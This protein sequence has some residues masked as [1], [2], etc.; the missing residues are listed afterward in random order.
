[1]A[2]PDTSSPVQHTDETLDIFGRP[3]GWMLHWGSGLVVILFGL[4]I[5]FAGLVRYP[6]KILASVV[7]T[8][9]NP[10]VPV[11]VRMDGVIHQ[12][13]V[14]DGSSVEEG[15]PLLL[16]DNPAKLVDVQQL[17]SLLHILQAYNSPVDLLAGKLPTDLAVGSLG[18]NYAQLL[19]RSDELRHWLQRQKNGQRVERIEEQLHELRM[20]RQNMEEQLET[21]RLEV[22]IAKR[23]LEQF[24]NLLE[25]ESA[26][27]LEV[28]QSATRFLRAQQEEQE[29][30]NRLNINQSQEAV[31]VATRIALEEDLADQVIDKWLAWNALVR[32]LKQ[33]LTEW[34]ERYLLCAPKDGIISFFKPLY[35]G[36]FLKQHEVLFGIISIESSPVYQAEGLLPDLASGKIQEGSK[37]YIELSAYPQREYGQLN[38]EVQSIALASA[39]VGTGYRVTLSLPE[40]L[41][42]SY[43]KPL[44][45]RHQMTGQAILL[46]ENRSLIGRLLDK[47]RNLR[48]NI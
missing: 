18:H 33:E 8:T 24:Q 25:R 27:Q 1:M 21:K 14:E 13:F 22:A 48:Q 5:G 34:K 2:A 9:S 10:P 26:S 41:T 29:H 15:Q 37:A 28:D 38:A 47:L 31:L 42:S 44:P 11:V 23:N 7:I 36:L 20:L 46:S 19:N 4:L 16:F 35:P 32:G 40:A 45:F 30:E 43:N 12:V 17:D 3:S 39:E 6:D